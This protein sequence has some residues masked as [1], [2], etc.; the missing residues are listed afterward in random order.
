MFHRW[1]N[2]SRPPQHCEYA[3]PLRSVFFE[4]VLDLLASLLQVRLGLITL[5]LGL[6]AFI[7]GRFTGG[8]FALAAKLVRGILDFVIQTHGVSPYGPRPPACRRRLTLSIVT[9]APDRPQ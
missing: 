7:T 8:F 9:T 2:R 3:G 5:T 1:P 4:D 6:Q